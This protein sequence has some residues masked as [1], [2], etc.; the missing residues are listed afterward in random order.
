MSY[1][2]SPRISGVLTRALSQGYYCNTFPFSLMELSEVNGGRRHSRLGL[3]SAGKRG[4][5]GT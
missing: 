1:S 3:N 4:E 5:V 2:L